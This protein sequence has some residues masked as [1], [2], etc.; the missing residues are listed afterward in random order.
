MIVHV[1]LVVQMILGYPTNI[2]DERAFILSKHRTFVST[3]YLICN[4]A[5]V[6]ITPWVDGTMLFLF[7]VVLHLYRSL[8]HC[9]LVL[10]SLRHMGLFYRMCRGFPLN[11]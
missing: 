8:R 1:Q 10:H 11:L 7:L 5:F 6:S 4:R 3:A 9:L 2:V